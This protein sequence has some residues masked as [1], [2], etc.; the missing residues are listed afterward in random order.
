MNKA[1]SQDALISIFP[2]VLKQEPSIY[3]LAK[4]TAVELERL[5]NCNQHLKLYSIID[6]LEEDLLDILAVDLKVD[7]YLPNA[8]ITAKR[9]QIK[10]CFFVHKT[11][12][13]KAAMLAALSAICPGTL[14]EE[15]FEY[16]GEPYHFRITFDITNQTTPIDYS[17]LKRFVAIF[18]PLRAVLDESDARFRLDNVSYN[19]CTVSQSKEISITCE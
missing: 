1:I 13:T 9:E 3:A 11:I 18:K 15:W 14:L 19:V 6:S 17:D 7:W 8:T 4:L 5:Y 12:G 10:T 2:E 16:G